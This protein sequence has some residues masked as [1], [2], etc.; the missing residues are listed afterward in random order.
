MNPENIIR[1]NNL[2]AKLQKN[3]ALQLSDR[4]WLQDNP[5]PSSRY[6]APWIIA[7][8][9]PLEPGKEHIITIQCQ[10]I[11]QPYPIVPTFTI[12]FEKGGY[13]QLKAVVDA[14]GP[15][16]NMKQSTKLSF[17]MLPGIT[18]ALQC[19]SDSGLL[20]V[21]YQGWVPDN[22][23]IPMWFESIACNRFAMKKE[24]ISENMIAYSCCGADGTEDVFQFLV[25]WYSVDQK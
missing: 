1:R 8:V 25:N 12:P 24:V 14:K 13:I 20:M 21:S 7:D 3:E 22:Q 15:V 6:G 23:P 18:A 10:K 16:Q 17:R 9:I 5:I 19:R 4:L 2:F 11:S